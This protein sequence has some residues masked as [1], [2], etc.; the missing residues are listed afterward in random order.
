MSDEMTDK[1]LVDFTE[2]LLKTKPEADP[3]RSI[4]EETAPEPRKSPF[5]FDSKGNKF[6]PVNHIL[7]DDG[8]PKRTKDGEFQ[9]RPHAKKKM[10]SKLDAADPTKAYNPNKPDEEQ[11]HETP[12]FD[13][14]VAASGSKAC[15]GIWFSFWQLLGGED[16][17]P[18]QPEDLEMRTALENWF[19]HKQ[20]IFNPIWH[21]IFVMMAYLTKRIKKCGAQIKGWFSWLKNILFKPR[22]KK[23]ELAVVPVGDEKPNEDHQE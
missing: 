7:G 4:E 1:D 6:D 23:E 17:K 12:K 8:Q 5:L 13:E 18:S 22:K 3:N 19:I 14:A 16:W 20:I 2:D 10:K 11:T 9:W 15:S 21:V